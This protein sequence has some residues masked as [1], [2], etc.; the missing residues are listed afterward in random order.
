MRIPDWRLSHLPVPAFVCRRDGKLLGFN[1]G[2]PSMLGTF[3]LNNGSSPFDQLLWDETTGDA[4]P[5]RDLLSAAIGAP[6]HNQHIQVRRADGTRYRIMI[7]LQ[8]IRT[9]ADRTVAVLCCPGSLGEDASMRV[10]VARHAAIIQNSDDAIL[11]KDLNGVITSWN[12][13]AE[14]I[15]GYTAE[16]AIGRPVLMLIP[17]GRL[18]EEPE[19]LDRLRRGERIDHYETMRVRKD[20]TSINMSLTVSPIRSPDGTIV[21]ASKIGRDITEQYR[22]RER[23]ELLMREINHRVNNVFAITNAIVALSTPFAATAKDLSRAVRE[24]LDA[25]SRAQ[26]L[27]RPGLAGEDLATATTTIAALVDTIAQPYE[28]KEAPTRIRFQGPDVTVAGGAVSNLALVIHEFAANAAKYGALSQPEGTVDLAWKTDGAKLTL[29][30]VE[31][32]GPPIASAPTTTGFGSLLS[33][34]IVL[35]QFGG[36]M[37][38]DWRPSGLVATLSVPVTNLT[39]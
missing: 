27:S 9:Q 26:R 13:A 23:Q 21:G 7:G 19:I 5:G 35:D 16:E 22:A 24:R 39:H 18:D 33:R 37:N 6:Q 12:P 29:T 25:L 10:V 32:G 34:R 8:A 31:Q 38:L 20:G 2:A 17:P 1:G 30:W 4:R 15:F 36:A 14:R 28:T 3:G 11:S